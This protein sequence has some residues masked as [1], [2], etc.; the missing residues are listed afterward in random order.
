VTDLAVVQGMVS[1]IN[2]TNKLTEK[3]AILAKYPQ[4][5]DILRYVYDEINLVY[6][7]TSK[8]LKKRDDLIEATDL[9]IEELLDALSKREFTGHKA[10]SIVNGF[11]EKNEDY[12]DLVYNIIDRNLKTRLD[13][14]SVNKV[15]KDCIPTFNV[16]LAKNYKDH[17]KSVD[18]ENGWWLASR[19]LDGVR[20]L[21]IIDADGNV[22]MKSR[23]GKEFF[24][25]QVIKD[26][27][28]KLNLTNTVFDGEV[29][30]VDEI[31]NESFSGIMSLIKKKDY[32]IANPKFKVFDKLT[33]EEFEAEQGTT[34]F[35]ERTKDLDCFES[36]AIGIVEQIRI[37][38]ESDLEEY[39]A[40][41]NK[42]G[43]EGLIL[44]NNTPYEGKRTKNMLK[45]KKFE[46]AEYTVIDVANGSIRYIEDSKEVE[47]DLLSS[48]TIE[49]KGCEVGV[50]SGFSLEQRKRFYTHPEE[51]IGKVI[52]VQYFE[53]TT[54]KEGGYS[55]RFP[56]IKHIHEGKRD[57]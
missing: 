40:I 53:E 48:V 22:T 9:N 11:I 6:G 38:N 57:T 3:V 5:K 41:A 52:T 28:K 20:C 54:N 43:W 36:N 45:V 15:F 1:E 13:V 56:V 42:R 25:L 8:N 14:K 30:L 7:V 26:E 37:N 23:E 19:K 39:V 55:L 12:R 31:G 50:G 24:T 16:T 17:A 51:I 18:F 46:D 35:T 32:T 34:S 2:T 29:C 44:R 27:L 47:E 21:G 49:H 4:C 10:L 33:L